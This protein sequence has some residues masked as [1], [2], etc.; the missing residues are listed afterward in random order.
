MSWLFP[1]GMLGGYIVH[2][3]GITNAYV[4]ICSISIVI[5]CGFIFLRD[6]PNAF[7]KEPE[8]NCLDDA[9]FKK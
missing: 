3:I 2:L 7:E 9:A 6:V 8:E 5:N 4:I 1:G